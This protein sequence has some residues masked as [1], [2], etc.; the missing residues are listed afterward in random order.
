M[1][2]ENETGFLQI[3]NSEINSL[4]QRL[5][6]LKTS[7]GGIYYDL[8]ERKF[9]SCNLKGQFNLSLLIEAILRKM[10]TLKHLEIQL[11]LSQIDKSDIRKIVELLK[12]CS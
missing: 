6:F 10:P 3:K 11:I 7:N 9:I 4:T 8:E 1:I 12:I 5:T 2:F